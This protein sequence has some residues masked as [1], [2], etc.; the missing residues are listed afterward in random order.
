MRENGKRY[1]TKEREDE[2]EWK[3]IFHK[4][5]DEGEW[6]EIFHIGEMMRENRKTIFHRGEGG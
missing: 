2:G 1:F 3:E 4:G 6:K 5:E